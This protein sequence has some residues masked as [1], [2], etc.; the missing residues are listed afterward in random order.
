MKT[1]GAE[2]D[3]IEEPQGDDLEDDDGL[4]VG[5]AWNSK[6]REESDICKVETKPLSTIDKGGWFTRGEQILEYVQYLDGLAK[7]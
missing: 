3:A 6:L 1:Y 5:E 4:A 7:R 2:Q